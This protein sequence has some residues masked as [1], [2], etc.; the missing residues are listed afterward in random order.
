MVTSL[1]IAVAPIDDSGTAEREVFLSAIRMMAS[2]IEKAAPDSLIQDLIDHDSRKR[3]L[4]VHALAR[5]TL[6]TPQIQQI[7]DLR[8]DQQR[9]PWVRMSALDTLMEIEREKVA[10]ANDK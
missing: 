3:I 10:V 7:R 4:A 8:D 1:A 6:N 5:R 9:R 2:K